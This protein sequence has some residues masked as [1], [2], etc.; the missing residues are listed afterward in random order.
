GIGVNAGIFTIVNAVLLRPLDYKDPDRLVV[1][2]NKHPAVM[3]DQ[4]PTSPADFL[5]W[6]RQ[7]TSFESMSA[8]RNLNL[9]LTGSG[10]P[11]RLSATSIS[12]NGF[13]VM[14][15]PAK[16]G[17]TFNSQDGTP[18]S[19]S[20][21]VI[22]DGLWKRRF[23]SDANIVGKDISLNGKRYSV[24]GVMPAGYQLPPSFT[25]GGRLIN[26]NTDVWIA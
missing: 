21:V 20:T 14:G 6:K 24:V 7:A 3:F 26:L 16:L 15:V 17:R 13:D 11:E 22:S 10:E 18:A 1:I 2:W 8:F 19:A 25:F 12:P 4:F 23:A 9:N 5:D